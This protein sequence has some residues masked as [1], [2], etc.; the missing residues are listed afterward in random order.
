[1]RGLQRRAGFAALAL[2]LILALEM[3]PN[4]GRKSVTF[5]EPAHIGAGFSYLVKR[6]FR[7]N[8]QHPPLMK[9]VAAV[10]LMLGGI[11]WP[12]PDRDWDDMGPQPDPLMQWTIGSRVLY[13]NDHDRVVALARWPCLLLTL[14][15]GG[16]LFLWG[17]EIVGSGAALAGLALFALDP[18]IVAHGYLVTTDAGFALF[19]VLFCWAAWRYMNHRTLKRLLY[20]AL[21]LGGAF[22]AKFTGLALG[23]IFFLLLI[24][25]VRLLPAA[26]P[27]Q[28]STLIDPFAGAPAGP[29]I[30]WSL[31]LVAA[32][33]LLAGV[34]VWA[35]YFFKS[36]LLYVTGLKL[37][38]ADHD[39]TY[40]PFMAGAFQPRF[41]TYYLIVYLL[42]E[43]LPA[44]V[45]AWIGTMALCR[46][47][48]GAPALDRAFL[49]VP[50]A[51]LFLMYTLFSDNLGMRYLIPVLPFL[52]LAGGTGAR[53]LWQSG[54]ALKRGLAAAL[55]VWLGI[56]AWGIAPDHLSF[57][58]ESA[59]LT[60]E[61]GKIGRDA[62]S[63]CG[64]LWLDDSNVDWG[65]GVKELAAW[66]QV[67]APQQRI[68]LAYFGT[69][70]PQA[71]GIEF[72]R[73]NPRDLEKPL[74]PGLYAISAHL[75]AR[76]RGSLHARYGDGAE[77][78]IAHTQPAA[79]VGHAF[80]VYEIR[81]GT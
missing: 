46:R 69:G 16:V 38:N 49:F 63:A 65:Q 60:T 13:E 41:W 11:R 42:K 7:L 27:T 36:P 23:P 1:M 37:V 64:T 19:T 74:P 5:D 71:V 59:C 30:V 61:P 76:A 33:S 81:P 79:V 52:H 66:L 24:L 68:G 4:I 10:P 75:L 15:L 43:P 26:V 9:E 39:A 57:F 21:A 40:R 12:V 73:V 6:E 54:S 20:C 48:T 50:P 80:Y 45:L 14:L 77:N 22:A 31:Y 34:V 18:N 8:L 55:F 58:N 70:R 29:R 25:A 47:E 28:P 44:I 3:A 32:V 78:W 56:N 72:D 67:H 53:A 17:R 51:F 62:G 2:L 35:I